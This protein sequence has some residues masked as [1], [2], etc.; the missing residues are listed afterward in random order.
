MWSP[1]SSLFF[2]FVQFHLRTQTLWL[3]TCYIKCPPHSLWLLFGVTGEAQQGCIESKK[4]KKAEGELRG[5]QSPVIL[6]GMSLRVTH[7]TSAMLIWSSVEDEILISPGLKW[8]H[9]LSSQVKTTLMWTRQPLHCS[10]WEGD[11][12]YRRQDYLWTK[13]FSDGVSAFIWE[14]KT[15]GP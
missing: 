13:R 6:C 7:F 5:W 3:I 15:L 12:Q 2:I 4:A 14:A 11:V 9:G 8:N 10:L 1:T